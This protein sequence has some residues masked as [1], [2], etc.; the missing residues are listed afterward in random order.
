MS[1][2][3]EGWRLGLAAAEKVVPPLGLVHIPLVPYDRLRG[4]APGNKSADEWHRLLASP[5]STIRKNIYL[6]QNIRGDVAAVLARLY[7]LLEE[8][9]AADFGNVFTSAATL[10]IR[11]K[12]SWQGRYSGPDTIRIVVSHIA[13]QGMRFTHWIGEMAILVHTKPP[14]GLTLY[15]N[16]EEIGAARPLF[17]T[18]RCFLVQV[19]EDLRVQQLTI[20]TTE[21]GSRRLRNALRD[22]PVERVPLKIGPV[23]VRSDL[24][25][26]SHER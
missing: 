3:M 20:R 23:R 24:K 6:P 13:K 12:P 4:I 21:E 25:A 19:R 1:D 18:L 5:A 10:Q 2:D 9:E 11:M 16:L 17:C 26:K 22:L 8:P 15:A 7:R 14:F